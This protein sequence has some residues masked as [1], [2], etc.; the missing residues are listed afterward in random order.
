MRRSR[1][2][3][4]GSPV[5]RSTRNAETGDVASAVL[6]GTTARSCERL[7]MGVPRPV[8]QMRRAPVRAPSMTSFTEHSTARWISLKSSREKSAVANRRCSPIV[9]FRGVVAAGV[10]IETADMAISIALP[11]IEPASDAT[12]EAPVLT[13]SIATAGC[14][15]DSVNADAT[16]STPVGSGRGDHLSLVVICA[17]G[18]G[19]M[20]TCVMSMAVNPST[21]AWCVLVTRAKRPSDSPSMR[22]ISQSG[23]PLSRGRPM[24]RPTSSLS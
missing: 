23:R 20:M 14:T 24:S 2:I 11:P 16:S 8:S 13:A 22:Y 6:N 9:T 1:T 4:S 3:G 12:C 17:S 10:A 15:S 18:E 5:G 7:E 19:S 21:S